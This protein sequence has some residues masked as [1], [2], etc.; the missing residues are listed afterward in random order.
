M[1]QRHAPARMATRVFPEIVARAES[2]HIRAG[3][4]P[5][6]RSV[7]WGCWRQLLKG[8]PRRASRGV[9]SLTRTSARQP[10]FHMTA[11]RSQSATAA[12]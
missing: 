3:A 9:D 7:G 10:I 6:T 5:H 1:L 8:Q 4:L 12:Y 2:H 11:G